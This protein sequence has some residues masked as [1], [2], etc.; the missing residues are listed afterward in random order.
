MPPTIRPAGRLAVPRHAPHGIART[1]LALLFSV[2]M[3]AGCGGAG[4]SG[5][6]APSS[7]VSVVREASAPVLSKP[8]PEASP[9][10]QASPSP[11]PASA[12]SAMIVPASWAFL[13][14]G[15]ILVPNVDGPTITA[16]DPNT[17]SRT[18]LLTLTSPNSVAYAADGTLYVSEYDPPRVIRYDP[19]TDRTTVVASFAAH[20]HPL[21]MAF[22][23]PASLIVTASDG[24][25]VRLDV[26]TGA[27]HVITTL[28]D[29]HP[30]AVAVAAGQNTIFTVTAWF[31]QVLAI[32]ASTGVL[33]PLPY[34]PDPG[35]VDVDGR[36]NLL[37]ADVFDG[38]LFRLEPGS[39]TPETVNRH[40]FSV[41]SI[42]ADTDGT[43]V[44]H[45]QAV[46]SRFDMN[47][48]VHEIT[49]GSFLSSAGRA[50]VVPSVLLFARSLTVQRQSQRLHLDGA[51]A[52]RDALDV[53]SRGFT[54]KVGPAVF[55]VPEG[56]FA[57]L[58][59]DRWR[60]RTDG[61]TIDITQLGNRQ[62]LF[63]LDAT[64][65]DVATIEGTVMV[66]LQLNALFD[67]ATTSLSAVQHGN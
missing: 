30:Y 5:A 45:D 16:I 10:P 22:E 58:G 38:W 32:N 63:S 53:P 9:S 1:A 57:P 7:N 4:G 15:T 50:D 42:A 11:T 62:Y 35:D 31:N 13:P 44:G 41:N 26:Q 8:T 56:G 67:P 27:V 51:F 19:V 65:A 6:S 25:I 36:G 40:L 20:G 18:P 33:K 34:M 48:G 39:T 49:R 17:G 28:P 2:M 14:P 37:V 55:A 3:L 24:A 60:W 43:V 21:D 12:K 29:Y 66:S 61:V 54:L 59:K 23:S 47:D 64:P 52:M 46:L